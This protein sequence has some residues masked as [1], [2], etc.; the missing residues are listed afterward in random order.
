[1]AFNAKNLHYEKQEPAFLRR[2]K[3]E[4]SGDRRTVSVARPRKPRLETGDDDGPTIVDEE[5]E[6]LTKQEYEALLQGK[7]KDDVLTTDVSTNAV[8]DPEPQNKESLRQGDELLV[9]DEMKPSNVVTN[10]TKK[11]KHI[12]AVGVELQLD[13][14]EA[15]GAIVEPET[16]SN[17]SAKKKH[18]K[19]IKLS[20]DEPGS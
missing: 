16:K 12:K 10:G 18:K 7:A 14:S 6:N 13:Q 3:G 9:R 8:P 2:L 5:G 11:R 20:F 1:M 17:H 4:T 15:D 19:K